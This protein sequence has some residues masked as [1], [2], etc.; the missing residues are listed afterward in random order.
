MR[1][2]GRSAPAADSRGGHRP[3]LADS[4]AS[5][6]TH[7]DTRLRS[8]SVACLRDVAAWKAKRSSDAVRGCKVED[9]CPSLLD[10]LNVTRQETGGGVPCLF[11]QIAPMSHGEAAAALACDIAASR[12]RDDR[13]FLVWH[14]RATGETS[15]MPSDIDSR[16]LA[17]T[18]LENVGTPAAPASTEHL[19]GLVAEAI[20]RSVV[21]ETDVGIGIP[22]RVEGHDW[23]ATDPG[24]DGLTVYA[25]GDGYCYRLWE[26]KYHGSGQPV[27]DTV[28][29]ACRQVGTRALSYLAR[30]SL[31]AQHI[32]D[33]Q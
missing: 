16:V 13:L 25:M 6:R 29:D 20:W 11:G 3:P 9:V 22:I 30:F 4:A 14:R 5:A 2:G 1:W 10:L 27:R 31:V 32:T 23:S 17:A 18:L 28:N 19:H 24:G 33:D 15:E 12:I 21:T 7:F 26:S 8:N